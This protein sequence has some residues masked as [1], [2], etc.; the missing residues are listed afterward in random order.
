M[1]FGCGSE[2]F[3]PARQSDGSQQANARLLGDFGF[4]VDGSRLTTVRS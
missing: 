2:V 3:L 4:G 1:I